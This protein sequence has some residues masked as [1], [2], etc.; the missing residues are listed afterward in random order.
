MRG[1]LRP[2]K[3]IGIEYKLEKRNPNENKTNEI[4]HMLT[5]HPFQN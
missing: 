5:F 2:R 1:I 4:H 3:D